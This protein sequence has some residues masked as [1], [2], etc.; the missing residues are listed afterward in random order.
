MEFISKHKILTPKQFGFQK[1]KSTE[2]AINEIC[3]N[4]KE[5]F[6]NKESAFGIFL[7]FA[8]AFDTVNHEILLTK[9]EYYGIRGIPLQWF[10]S[11]LQNRQQ[12]TGIDDT[13]SDI[14]TV[15]CG[16]PQGSILGPLLFLLY[17]NDIISSSNVLKFFLFADD[18]TIFYSTKINAETEHI[19][20]T[21]LNKVNNW[22][23]C[24][25]LSL[26]ID[27]S[28]YLNFTLLK[29]QQKVTIKIA[30]CPLQH[31]KVVKYLGVLIDENLSWKPHIDN[32]NLKIRKGTGMIYKIRDVV[33]STTLKTLYYSFIYPYLDYNI[34]NWSIAPNTHLNKLRT[35]NKRAVKAMLSKPLRENSNPLFKKL[36]IL[37]LD[38]LINFRR[39]TF[40]WKI[41]NNILP[42][43][44]CSWFEHN[45]ENTH[46]LTS[47]YLLK[48]PRTLFAKNHNTFAAV[49]LWNV[50]IPEEIKVSNTLKQF[51][52][53]YKN[54]L[55]YL[56]HSKV[57]ITLD[58]QK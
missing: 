26:N 51:K 25:K 38:S 14:E 41:Q 34:I 33:T 12:Y 45:K 16:V 20:N 42:E 58:K 6:E 18:T 52:L 46:T 50:D 24:N 1:I 2:L 30:K 15:T 8:K 22:L 44:T 3:S 39:G 31:K 35:S 4:L 28:C 5:T 21:E 17:I 13:L 19:L 56:N 55:L 10:K 27:K 29:R 40:M 11:Y 49:K 32:I 48:N 47:K 7:D 53:N 9:L 43:E 36:E 37:P 57:V 23:N 54:H